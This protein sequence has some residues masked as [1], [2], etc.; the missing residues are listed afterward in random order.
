MAA[1]HSAQEQRAQLRMRLAFWTAQDRRAISPGPPWLW[2]GH[3]NGPRRPSDLPEAI[4][5]KLEGR[6]QVL[7]AELVYTATGV[8]QRRLPRWVATRAAAAAWTA[9]TVSLLIT[10][11]VCM[12]TGGDR[13]QIAGIS[14]WAA[15]GCAALAAATML[16]TRWAHRDPLRLTAAEL[17]QV[18]VAERTV[19]WNPLAGE[20]KV[21]PAGAFALEGVQ[22]CEQLRAHPAWMLPGV[23]IMRW[24]FVPDEEIFQIAR[25]AATLDSYA[26]DAAARRQRG[27][28]LDPVY[29]DAARELS[30]TLLQ[31]LVA[32]R[33][34]LSTISELD[35]AACAL[36][37]PD[38][39]SQRAA[40][41]A[42]QSAAENEFASAALGEL[43]VDVGAFHR[44]CEPLDMQYAGT[45]N[46]PTNADHRR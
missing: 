35:Q 17:A 36:A 21:S 22:L 2:R 5:A 38:E 33:R 20:G 32:L 15:L 44:A 16:L 45:S 9:A 27:A 12:H 46:M 11:A 43:T 6:H 29:S 40:T 10:A 8:R 31:R 41:A 4:A 37:G 18:A 28:A 7:P 3:L 24:Q 1:G 42:L 23:E 14:A 19:A 39:A 34:C 26:A 30:E 13:L 25:A